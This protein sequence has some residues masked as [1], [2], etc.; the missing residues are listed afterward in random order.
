MRVNQEEHR[1]KACAR[2]ED[3]EVLRRFRTTQA[4]W[5]QPPSAVRRSEAQQWERRQLPWNR[6]TGC[7]KSREIMRYRG[8]AALQ[9]RVSALESRSAL[10][11]VL[12]KS[13][14]STFSAAALG[15]WVCLP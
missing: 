2:K 9:R 1:G 11:P 3:S 10:A 6:F 12:R 13:A 7:W 15:C 14:A 8:R 5:G 4:M